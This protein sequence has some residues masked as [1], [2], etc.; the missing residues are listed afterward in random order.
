MKV[1]PDRDTTEPDGH[2]VII[3]VLPFN[4]NGRCKNMDG[5]D[6]EPASETPTA[7]T[8]QR[9]LIAGAAAIACTAITVTGVWVRG[10]RD[11]LALLTSIA[12]GTRPLG[13]FAILT[14]ASGAVVIATLIVSYWLLSPKKRTRA[15][16]ALLLA[17]A[18][19][20]IGKMSLANDVF[21]KQALFV[22]LP[23]LALFATLLLQH[24]L[25]RRQRLL[26]P[27]AGATLILA[28]GLLSPPRP[29]YHIQVRRNRRQELHLLGREMREHGPHRTKRGHSNGRLLGLR[30][31]RPIHDRE[32]RRRPVLQP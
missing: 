30:Q 27:I 3:A 18:F 15:L 21:A 9:T 1:L 11:G 4:W 16:A 24:H 7:Q 17:A 23:L 6:I 28:I 32:H 26:G 8:R 25:T 19:V 31:P 12:P 2:T 14:S 10:V 29:R 22:A 5:H 20:L 13:T